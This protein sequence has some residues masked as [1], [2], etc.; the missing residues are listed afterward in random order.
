MKSKTEIGRRLHIPTGVP[1]DFAHAVATVLLLGIAGGHTWDLIYEYPIETSLA[2]I[3]G[4]LEANDP[5]GLVHSDLE[6]WQHQL[7]GH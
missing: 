5:T 7:Q 6:W 4:I 1:P 3:E 2:W